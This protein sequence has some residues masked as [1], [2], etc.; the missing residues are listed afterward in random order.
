MAKEI[1]S[2]TGPIIALLYHRH[3]RLA[4][5]HVGGE[6][7][8]GGRQGR[9]ARGQTPTVQKFLRAVGGVEFGP[10]FFSSAASVTRGASHRENLNILRNATYHRDRK[11]HLTT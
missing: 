11:K 1:R 8:G 7:G 6:I 10:K 4:G 5:V 2:R 9:G 3:V